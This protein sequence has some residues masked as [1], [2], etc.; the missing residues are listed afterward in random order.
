MICATCQGEFSKEE[1][2]PRPV[3]CPLCGQPPMLARQYRIEEVLGQSEA[4]TTYRATR[5]FDGRAMV[6]TEFVYSGQDTRRIRDYFTQEVRTLRRLNHPGLAEVF[7][8]F[9]EEDGSSVKRVLISEFVEGQT[10]MREMQLKRTHSIREVL[11]MLS[12]LAQTL[13]YLH[14]QRPAVVHRDIKPVNIMRRASDGRLILV[15]LGVVRQL[16]FTD[17]VRVVAGSPGFMAPEQH[18]GHPVPGSDVYGLAATAVALLTEA[19]PASLSNHGQLKWANRVAVGTG[20]RKLIDE[21]LAVEPEERPSPAEVARRAGE[22]LQ[23][24][25]EVV[26]TPEEPAGEWPLW[27]IILG[28]TSVLI[29][30]FGTAMMFFLVSIF[31][32]VLEPSSIK[33]EETPSVEQ[34]S[35]EPLPALEVAEVVT[36]QALAIAN[37]SESE[38]MESE[39]EANE[40]ES[41]ATERLFAH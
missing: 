41:E 19:T 25:S 32:M 37:E 21:M 13:D 1:W 29:F 35:V 6:A 22:L 26:V 15:N 34:H 12:Q 28:V 24:P 38:A 9:V 2:D 17:R 10:L 11:E 27:S 16:E 5:F 7:E 33:I 4:G 39:S 3:E 30:L 14:R 36:Q 23:S 18:D 31:V 40:S 20:L 8:G